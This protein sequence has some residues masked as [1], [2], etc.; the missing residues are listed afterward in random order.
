MNVILLSTIEDQTYEAEIFKR[1]RA[2]VDTVRADEA[3]YGSLAS[4][5][6]RICKALKHLSQKGCNCR[7]GSTGDGDLLNGIENLAVAPNFIGRK[8]NQRS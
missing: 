6:N 4:H 3:A 5:M 2:L 8:F 1:R 7:D